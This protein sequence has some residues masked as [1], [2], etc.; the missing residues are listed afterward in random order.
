MFLSTKR[1]PSAH[2]P[3]SVLHDRWTSGFTFI[4]L[5]IVIAIAAILAAIAAPSFRKMNRN[6]AI[7]GAADELIS[8]IQ[9]AR[10]EAIR[11]NQTV[12]LSLDQR[13]WQVFVDANG[14]HV[15]DGNEVLLRE[16]SYSELIN[17]QSSDTALWFEFTPTG[18]STSSAGRFPTGIC[19]TN[20][21]DPPV[22]RWVFFPARASSPVIEASCPP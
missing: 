20:A 11:T 3:R 13:T 15:H 1:T 12:T 14:N 7:R 2:F 22:Q 6:M 5:L 8:D 16:G 17:A 9:F 18:M 21:D 19:L 4:E 10:S